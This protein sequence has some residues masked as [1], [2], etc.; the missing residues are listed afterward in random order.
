MKNVATIQV[1]C[2]LLAATGCSKDFIKE[3]PRTD[4]VSP[5]TYKEM[6]ALLDNDVFMNVTPVMG[7]LSADNYY[8]TDTYWQTLLLNHERNCYI[9]K[10]DIYEGQPNVTDWSISYTQVLHA[11]VV[12]EALQEL[13]KKGSLDVEG[14]NIRGMALFYRAHALFNLAQIFAPPYDLQT[15]HTDLGIPL[16]D[17]SDI[18]A[19][20]PR[21][22]VYATY[23]KIIQDLDAAQDLVPT[24]VIYHY[25]NRP[26]K[27]A[28]LGLKARVYLSMRQYEKA[29]EYADE[30]LTSYDSLLN[31][32]E[33]DTNTLSPF[34]RENK[35]TIFQSQFIDNNIF[36]A[37]VFPESVVD[38]ILYNSYSSSDLRKR[39]FYFQGFT[40]NIN[41]K[42][43][44]SG[45]LFPFTGIATDELM[46]IRAECYA[47]FDNINMAMDDL[48]NLLITRFKT[49]EYIPYSASTKEEALSIILEERRK[50]LAFRGLRWMDIRRLNKEGYNITLQRKL[51]GQMHT[52]SPNSKL[53]TLPIPPEVLR[54]S[55]ISDNDRI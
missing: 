14:K 48:N 31:F 38:S 21:S 45:V 1:I 12:L 13:E 8:L 4:L 11:N 42:G 18:N 9:W 16:R 40:G 7:E 2:L 36:S 3:N 22:T 52:I 35:E 25:K 20:F 46:L 27:P 50:E 33:L 30:A 43:S 17:K 41:L 53:Y 15:A 44:F 23:E 28:V 34:T 32:N 49:G 29:L 26:T 24:S 19:V 47:R 6:R 55:G 54:Q 5:S 51:N 37:I 39:L 10:P